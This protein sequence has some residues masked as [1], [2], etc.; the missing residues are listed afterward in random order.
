[1]EEGA[2]L[3][4]KTENKKIKECAY[5]GLQRTTIDVSTIIIENKVFQMAK[6]ES[7]TG[8][9]EQKSSGGRITEKNMC[10]PLPC[11]ALI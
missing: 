9:T 1:M 10:P 8:D 6:L 4:T 2:I 11:K 3:L 5:I 7:N